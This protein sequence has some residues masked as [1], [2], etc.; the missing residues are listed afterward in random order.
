MM[1]E[2]RKRCEKFGYRYASHR[3][4]P[5]SDLTGSI[6]ACTFKPGLLLAELSATS[7]GE[8][9]AWI[10]AD[11]VVIRPLRE[12]E[13]KAFDIAVTLREPEAIGA[14]QPATNYLNSGVVFARYTPAA[15]HF[16]DAW[17]DESVKVGGDQA[18]L[19]ELVG[20]GWTD[21]QWRASYHTTITGA[22][23]AQVL[24]LPALQWNYWHFYA[25]A[26]GPDVKI[27]HF[28][29]GFRAAAGDDWWRDA[30]RAAEA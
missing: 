5:S 4:D 13:V 18:A 23:N 24:I 14:T 30:L 11:A 26:P 3:L 20:S 9:A 29:H 28:K 22:C 25:G 10:D 8:I 19:N 15:A 6:P 1:A 12:L 2:N 7:L 17:V 16:L 27:V 21:D